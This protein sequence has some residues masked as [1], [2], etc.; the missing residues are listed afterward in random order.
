MTRN[1]RLRRARLG[2][3]WSQERAA[4]EAGIA[5]KTYIELETGKRTPHIGTLDLLCQAFH[6]P[7]PE[8]GYNDLGQLLVEGTATPADSS[9]VPGQS[10]DVILLRREER[11]AEEEESVSQ[12]A[13]ALLYDDL[14]FRVQR[15]IYETLSQRLSSSELRGK[16]MNVLAERSTIMDLDRR[17]LLRRLALIPVQTFGL[18]ALGALSSLA[19]FASEDILT[20]CAA[21]IMACEQLSKGIDLHLAYASAQAYLPTLKRITKDYPSQ[22]KS[23]SELVAQATLLLAALSLHVTGSKAAIG[24]A[25]QAVHYSEASSNLELVLTA[26]GQLAWIFS[27]DKQYSKA[28]ETAQQAEYLLRQAK[29]IH[30]LVQSN[31][32]AV[33]GAYSAQNGKRAEALTALH[34]ASHMFSIAIPTDGYSY[35]DYDAS[36]ISLTWG[37][38]HARTGHPQEALQAFTEV[39]DPTTLTTKMPVS[40]R[41][42]V[43]FLNH[44]ALASVKSP[45]KDMEQT[46]RYW[47]AAVKGA[48]ALHS[49]QR[50][51]EVVTAYEIM[52]GVWPSEQRIAALRELIVHWE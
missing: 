37:L 46:V 2:M 17:K 20:H 49:E 26:L 22:R 7:P 3:R 30:P 41:V 4:A 13:F 44:M 24:Y 9:V 16:L 28:L 40:E 14:E 27:S 51:S 18:S 29:D 48:K 10:N 33:L 25:K 43:E 11:E 35:M 5:R 36:E 52:E 38:A 32:Y 42:R 50:F 31:T 8:L 15:V 6:A 45:A 12:E 23:A 39:V 21:G 34:V 1:E 47:V 19:P